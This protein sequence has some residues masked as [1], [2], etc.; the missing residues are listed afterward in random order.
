MRLLTDGTHTLTNYAQPP[1][2]R[3][4]KRFGQHFLVN[5]DIIACIAAVIAPRPDDRIVEI[6]PGLG[7][8]THAILPLAG[9]M[10]VVELDRD[11]IPHLTASCSDLGE[12]QIFQADVLDFD[13]SQLGDPAHKLRIIGNLPYNIS[14]PLLFHLMTYLPIIKDM[15]FMMQKEVVDRLAAAP[16]SSAYGRLS[17]MVQYY[18]RVEKLFSVSP[19]AF[20]PP[21]KV[22]S[23][24]VR[25]VPHLTAP[26]VAQDLLMFST[27]VRLA[28]AQRRKMLHNT[29]RELV[30]STDLVKLEIDPNVRAERLTVS[31]FVK[32]SNY[33]TEKTA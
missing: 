24:I 9:K 2:H 4:R 11:V 33:L 16:G 23:A 31:D 3:P 7:A 1:F 21:P 29:L 32:I 28:F 12:L 8:L 22:E 26:V 15:C 19:F 6:G 18:C 27:V 10:I 14:T 25:L 20:D 13:F 5:R 17:V 30:S